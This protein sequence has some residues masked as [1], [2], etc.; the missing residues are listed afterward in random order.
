MH[1]RRHYVQ[2]N[3]FVF[4]GVEI[5]S[6]D[7]PSYSFK[8]FSQGY[9]FRR[10]SYSPK[11]SRYG[12]TESTNVS[13]TIMLRYK[14]IPCDK[15][16][17]YT[18]FAEM[19]LLKH[20]RLWSVHD[21]RLEWA[22]ASV[23]AWNEGDSKRDTLEIDVNFEL[24]EGVWHKA[25]LQ[26]TF[27]VP[28]SSCDFMDCYEFREIQPCSEGDCCTCKDKPAEICS[29]CDDCDTVREDMALCY[30][31]DEIQGFYDCR[32]GY[33]IVYDCTAGERY[34][35]PIGQQFCS[36][37]GGQ[38]AGILYSD[39]NIPTDGVTIHLKGELHN[40]YIEINGNGNW[41]EG[42]YENLSV[43]P[44]GS[45]YEYN[46]CTDCPPLPVDAW[47]KPENMTYGWTVNP[48]NNRLIIDPGTC[49]T[50]CAYIEIDA[51]AI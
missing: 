12:L 25:D 16:P 38:I 28:Y 13:L 26:K 3:E 15:R 37:C 40:P 19:E 32:S 29:C 46:G 7:T 36:E 43:Y 27:L 4:D 33:K 22:Y 6:E 50:V 10:G 21:N 14:N 45:V 41:I 35:S 24:P 39:T 1:Y 42:D 8:T 23:T 9:G 20:G 44:D 31:K 47:K 51:L 30:H 5:I 11:K 2:F 48:G 18:Q 49:C 34:F 17:F